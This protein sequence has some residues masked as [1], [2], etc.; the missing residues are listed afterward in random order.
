VFKVVDQPHPITVQTIVRNC[1][2]SDIH[3]ALLDLRSLWTNGYAAIDIVGTLFRVTKNS[4]LP[5]KI[6]L[7]FIKEI[8]FTHMKIADGCN[9]LLQLTGLCGRLCQL[10]L[11]EEKNKATSN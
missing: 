8:S 5:E 11:D 3:A 4:D 6:K 1:H 9:S 2:L 7:Q 10:A